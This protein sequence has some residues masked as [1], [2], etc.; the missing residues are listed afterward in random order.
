M[1]TVYMIFKPSIRCIYTLSMLIPT[2][3]LSVTGCDTP[4]SP[5]RRAGAIVAWQ[6]AHKLF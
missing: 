1:Y 3:S 6:D 2:V 4:Q 5:I